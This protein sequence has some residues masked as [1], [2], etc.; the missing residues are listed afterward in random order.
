[1]LEYCKTDK[2]PND[3]GGLEILKDWLNQR[4]QAFSEEAKN[5][6][7]PL[8][9]GVLLVGPQGTGKSLVAKAIG[10]SWSMPL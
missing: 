5:F 6:G 3:V 9:K 2:S 7:L 4:K 8:P 1:M 10:N